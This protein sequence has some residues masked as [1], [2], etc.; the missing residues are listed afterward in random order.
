MIVA[1]EPLVR[2]AELAVPAFVRDFRLFFSQ[3]ADV[4]QAISEAA[5]SP[6]GFTG[7]LR[8]QGLNARFGLPVSHATGCSRIAEY[9]Y[10]RVA[11]SEMDT[12]EAVNQ[13]VAVA[14]GL[15]EPITVDERQREAL[16][17]V[18]SFKRDLETEMAVTTATS[19]AP[20]FID[21]NGGWAIKPVRIRNGEVVKVPVVTLSLIWH[22]GSGNNHEAYLQMSEEDWATF[23]EKVGSL[24]NRRQ[25]LESLL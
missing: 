7:G 23:N 1:E 25:E 18:V 16:A 12:D 9:L 24:S 21:V 15:D 6:D 2:N 10:R 17:D 5:D 19:N 4:L 3:K 20:H 22:D 14:A 13:I 8:A 11:E